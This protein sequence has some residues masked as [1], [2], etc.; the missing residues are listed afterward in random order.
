MKTY[1]K[2]K[3]LVLLNG[4]KEEEGKDNN[5]MNNARRFVTKDH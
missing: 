1:R 5:D 3:R 4:E 2:L